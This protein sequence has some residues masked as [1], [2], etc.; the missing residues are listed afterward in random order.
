MSDSKRLQVKKNVTELLHRYLSA[1]RFA[2]V[3]SF[4]RFTEAQIM[5]AGR[6][7]LTEKIVKKDIGISEAHKV[8]GLTNLIFL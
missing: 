8:R 2:S 4:W 6:I 1:K 3:L 5:T 7:H